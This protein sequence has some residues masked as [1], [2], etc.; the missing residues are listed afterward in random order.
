MAHALLA[1]VFMMIS[2]VLHFVPARWVYA[3]PVP[4]AP[5]FRDKRGLL[6]SDFPAFELGCKIMGKE[7][8]DQPTLIA[9]S[10]IQQWF[11]KR[12]RR[13]NPVGNNQVWTT[14]GIEQLVKDT[15]AGDFNVSLQQQQHSS[16]FL[17][18]AREVGGQQQHEVKTLRE[19]LRK[20]WRAEIKSLG[21]VLGFVFAQLMIRAFG[22]V[23][24]YYYLSARMDYQNDVPS[25][26]A[27]PLW[28][29]ALPDGCPPD[30]RL[31]SF[32]DAKR[33]EGLR[34][35]FRGPPLVH[36]RGL[37]SKMWLGGSDVSAAAHYDDSHNLFFQ[38]VGEKRFVMLPPTAHRQ[39][40]LHPR[41][42]GSSRQA[43]VD[44]RQAA[45]LLNGTAWV[46]TLKPGQMLYVPSHWFH[47]VEAFSPRSVSVNMWTHS[48]GKSPA[49]HTSPQITRQ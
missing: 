10:P 22:G 30:D 15:E 48:L 37:S 39:L 47:Y 11:D 49:T 20:V 43:Q 38:A 26:L 28:Q 41:W 19:A 17:H 14:T 40:R 12:D 8:P 21:D 33:R 25:E 44:L 13:G 27:G 45:P 31:S 35:M 9:G 46:V 5:A 1:F 24:T 2:L 29:A 36:C 23:R 32:L 16:T 4:S 34:S 6:T 3:H 42:H 7:Y 18:H